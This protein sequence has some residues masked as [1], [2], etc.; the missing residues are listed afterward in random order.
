M[1]NSERLEL[2][3]LAAKTAPEPK[4]VKID[5]DLFCILFPDINLG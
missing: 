2:I 1:E 4:G 5:Y 3:E